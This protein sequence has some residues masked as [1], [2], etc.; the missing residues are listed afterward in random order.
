MSYNEQTLRFV[1]STQWDGELS[2]ATHVG[3]EG[4]KGEGPYAKVWLRVRDDKVDAARFET[5][6]CPAARA[7]CAVLC[8]VIEGK[9]LSVCTALEASDIFLLLGGLPEGKGHLQDL[10]VRALRDAVNQA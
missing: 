10:A 6:S 1:A 5:Y 2:D 3:T 4:T 8:W 7:S 9:A